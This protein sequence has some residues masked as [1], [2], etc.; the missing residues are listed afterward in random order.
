VFET[1]DPDAE[2]A[3]VGAR[4]ELVVAARSMALLRRLD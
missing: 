4:G 1:L 3:V 2:P